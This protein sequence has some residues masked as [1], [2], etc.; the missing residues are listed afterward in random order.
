M[1][2]IPVNRK[3]NKLSQLHLVLLRF[4]RPG[5]NKP[6][7]RAHKVVDLLRQ[8][9]GGPPLLV[10]VLEERPAGL[11]E[12]VRGVLVEV[13]H[14]DARREDREVRMPRRGELP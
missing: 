8:Q 1:K 3:E 7:L 6:E 13:G 9:R 10:L 5:Q 11:G 4:C 12:G 14:R 2:S